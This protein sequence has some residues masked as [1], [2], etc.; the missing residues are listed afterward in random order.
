MHAFV[1]TVTAEAQ[2]DNGIQIPDGTTVAGTSGVAF[3]ATGFAASSETF[4]GNVSV[5]TNTTASHATL[6][7]LD[8]LTTPTS[9][10]PLMAAAQISPRDPP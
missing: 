5:L 3:G 8:R 9:P 6:A 1:G 4:A 10:T 2:L 7:I